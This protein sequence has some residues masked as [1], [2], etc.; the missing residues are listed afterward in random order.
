MGLNGDA[1]SFIYDRSLPNTINRCSTS[2]RLADEHL[3]FA[4]R[5]GTTLI[6]AIIWHHTCAIVAIAACAVE[7]DARLG[8]VPASLRA[9][10]S[11]L[12]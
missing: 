4:Q 5:S 6:I 3:D 1:I 2:N 10:R 12:F 8:E 9:W 7:K 11:W